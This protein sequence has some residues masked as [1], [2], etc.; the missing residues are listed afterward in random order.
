MIIQTDRL[1]IRYFTLEDIDLV[2]EINNH[3]E[4]IL[5][6]GW[7][8]MS[9]NKCKS[10]LQTWIDAYKLHSSWGVFCVEERMTSEKVGMTFIYDHNETNEYEIGFRFRKDKWGN[11]YAQEITKEYLSYAKYKL[12]S[13]LVY[14]EVDSKN[15]NSLR[16]FEKM[17]FEKK[18]H[19]NGESGVLYEMHL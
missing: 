5:F 7:N 18:A 8:S 9:I 12:K 14:A 1:I 4:C 15:T 6:N 10:V 19:P 3:P 16:I 17:N 11:G 13:K 2:F